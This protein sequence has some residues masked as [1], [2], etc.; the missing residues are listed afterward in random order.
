MANWQDLFNQLNTQRN[1]F[2]NQPTPQVAM[3]G[4]LDQAKANPSIDWSNYTQPQPVAPQAPANSGGLGDTLGQAGKS[5]WNGTLNDLDYI[6]TKPI[7]TAATAVT[8]PLLYLKNMI[9]G[10]TQNQPNV[11]NDIK[12]IWSQPGSDVVKQRGNDLFGWNDQNHG[13]MA[14]SFS[15]GNLLDIGSQVFGGSAEGK[16]AGA[17][18]DLMKPLINRGAG[19]IYRQAVEEAAN[20][21]AQATEG[22]MNNQ[23]QAP[24]QYTVPQDAGV[25]AN[26]G[27]TPG[28]LN[29]WAMPQ[30][31]AESAALNAKVPTD[32][33]ATLGDA[34]TIEQQA[35]EQA[36][37]Y[38]SKQK[39]L[40]SF[41]RQM[42]P[43]NMQFP[44]IQPQP[45]QTPT[46]KNAAQELEQLFNLAGE[47]GT[48]AGREY[49]YL[50]GLYPTMAGT[51]GVSFDE[52]LKQLD[53]PNV[54]ATP[55]VNSAG[56]TS[57]DMISNL[58]NMEHK[59]LDEMQT[60]LDAKVGDKIPP[61]L[62]GDPMSLGARMGNTPAALKAGETPDMTD[63]ASM[64][65]SLGKDISTTD[66]SDLLNTLGK[67]TGLR[68]DDLEN[69][70]NLNKLN[71]TK[72]AFDLPDL[73][74]N[75]TGEAATASTEHPNPTTELPDQFPSAEEVYKGLG[76]KFD[77]PLLQQNPL[78]AQAQ[79][80]QFLQRIQDAM[81][82][83]GIMGSGIESQSV[84]SAGES[85]IIKNRLAAINNGKESIENYITKLAKET[86]QDGMNDLWKQVYDYE[87]GNLPHVDTNST[88]GK[89]IHALHHGIDGSE[90]GLQAEQSAGVAAKNLRENYF[91]ITMN[92]KDMPEDLRNIMDAAAS[93]DPHIRL[94]RRSL[95]RTYTLDRQ[96]PSNYQAQEQGYAVHDPFTSVA[97][98]LI[99]SNHDVHMAKMYQELRDNGYQSSRVSERPGQDLVRYMSKDG[100]PNVLNGSYV[101]KDLA[102]TLNNVFDRTPWANANI[103]V[104]SPALQNWDK[105][106]HF[107]R[108]ATLYTPM[109]HLH[110][111]FGN[112]LMAAGISPGDYMAAEKALSSAPDS[113]A[114]QMAKKTGALGEDFGQS[115]ATKIQRA[116]GNDGGLKGKLGDFYSN[117]QNKGLWNREKALRQAV[118]TKY[119]QEAVNRG[120]GT[121]EAANVARDSTLHHMVDYSNNNLSTFEKEVM[122]RVDPFYRWHKGNY[123]LQASKIVSDPAY[124]RKVAQA[125]ALMN[126]AQENMTGHDM[127]GNIGGNDLKLQVPMGDGQNYESYDPYLPFQETGKLIGQNPANT[128]FNRLNPFIREGMSQATNNQYYPSQSVTP[129]GKDYMTGN[130]YA[131][132]NPATSA[133]DQILARG[134]HAL[135]H[136]VLP[137]DQAIPSA[138]KAAIQGVQGATQTGKYP[139]VPALDQLLADLTGGFTQSSPTSEQKVF[140]Q[141]KLEKKWL[142]AYKKAA[143]RGK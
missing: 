44:Q 125:Q 35:M 58:L 82:K 109:T 95:D 80:P 92:M 93:T 13:G 131:I 116:L 14:N 5:L 69:I 17:V 119:F 23:P 76:D 67:G 129:T 96:F 111:V 21:T 124:M 87:S 68:P 26:I 91:P 100:N 110:N 24:W 89:L 57:K 133:L 45:L 94:N 104:I 28:V 128:M 20:P 107:F 136:T 83:Y 139:E 8:D 55:R 90:S 51:E 56:V 85:D 103:P 42:T 32:L 132:A 1:A 88:L 81:A 52:L 72:G 78:L 53:A 99:K 7:Q 60:A 74:E 19:S 106:T 43:T 29:D 137:T 2:A 108:N 113:L 33:P 77:S 64:L 37:N 16:V 59:P 120:L 62:N 102:S 54:G 27:S 121:S 97:S 112:A 101:H 40:P 4:V 18:G 47:N 122:S 126:N 11:Y 63:L 79:K 25:G 115:T 123:G 30:A 15:P 143:Q 73:L 114:V 31:G 98:R 39:P 75:P 66:K 84:K 36:N 86:G 38:M 105:M 61:V 41:D 134:G 3:P 10:N 140:K 135:T 118:F 71:P 49:E 70:A 117:F 34:P 6:F 12:S 50:Q 22:A 141:N 46:M 9:T 142:D 48:P 130:N 138:V 65:D 127:N